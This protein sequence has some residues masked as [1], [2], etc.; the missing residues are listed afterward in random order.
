MH[1]VLLLWDIDHTLIENGGVSKEIY[2]RAFELLAGRPPIEQPQTDG[3]TDVGIMDNL[4][5]A[6]NESPE[7]F[8]LK[9]RW[10]ALTQ[11]GL[12]LKSR[13]AAKGHA[14]PGASECLTRLSSNEGILQSVL[15]G[16]IE[17][18]AR[19]KLGAFGLDRHI[20][21]S[22]GGY[23]SDHARRA[24]LVAVAQRKAA[25]LVGFDPTSEPTVLIGDTTRDVRAAIDG[26]ALIVAVATGISSE[27]ELRDAGAHAVLLQLL[28][29]EAVEEAVGAVAAMRTSGQGLS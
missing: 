16:N 21:F 13:L 23:G 5:Q 14:L 8:P 19:V 1:R 20:D 28:P 15:T 6:N 18:N 25:Q 7:A 2:A 24:D 12:D 22:I 3:R 26:G 10:A 4:F 9:D 29:V 27:A 17:A 11:A